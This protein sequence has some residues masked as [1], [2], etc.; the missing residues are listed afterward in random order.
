MAIA[1]TLKIEGKKYD[2]VID[3]DYQFTQAIDITGRPSDRPRGGVIQ[4]SL[5]SP[6]DDNLFFHEWMRNMDSVHDGEIIFS[7]NSKG[8]ISDKTLK[9]TDAYCIGL[10]EHFDRTDSG[11][12]IMQ[13]TIATGSITFGDSCEF[14]L[15]D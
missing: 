8:T 3:V 14:K 2:T 13:L 5:P 15:I 4:L 10:H 1:A 11:A 12:M 9:F 6:D 7:V